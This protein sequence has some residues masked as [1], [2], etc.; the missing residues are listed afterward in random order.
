MTS[1]MPVV[2]RFRM[3]DPA[4]PRLPGF[5]LHDVAKIPGNS[6]RCIVFPRRIGYHYDQKFCLQSGEPDDQSGT[7]VTWLNREAA[8]HQIDSDKKA[9]APFISESPGNGESSS[10][11]FN[12]P[13]IYAY[14]CLYHPQEKGTIIVQS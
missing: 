3:C 1:Y 4:H 11:M 8:V 6:C 12:L 10:F 5:R 7:T 14:H 9:T 13:G 2:F